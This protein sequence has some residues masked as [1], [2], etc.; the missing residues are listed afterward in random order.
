MVLNGVKWCKDGKTS[1]NKKVFQIILDSKRTCYVMI[2][3]NK[4]NIY[5]NI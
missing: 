1:I 4:N 2:N 3:D 5:I